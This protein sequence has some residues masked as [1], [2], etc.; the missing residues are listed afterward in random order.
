[1]RLTDDVLVELLCIR[2]DPSLIAFLATSLK[3][4][5][6]VEDLD[7][8]VRAHRIL[9]FVKREL[10]RFGL[11]ELFPDHVRRGWEEAEQTMVR[12]NLA[13]LGEMESLVAAFTR[14]GI[15]VVLLEGVSL[16]LN[17]YRSVTVRPL[18]DLELLVREED[19]AQ[20]REIAGLLGYESCPPD[21]RHSH[22]APGRLLFCRKWRDLELCLELHYRLQWPLSMMDT[23]GAR[24][25]SVAKPFKETSLP[26]LKTED[27]VLSLALQWVIHRREREALLWLIDFREI[28]ERDIIFF[29]PLVASAKAWGLDLCLHLF[30]QEACRILHTPPVS[31]LA[32]DLAPRGLDAVILKKLN[33][34]RAA[35]CLLV[36]KPW[37]QFFAPPR[38]VAALAGKDS[39]A[40]LAYVREL[41][42]L[43]WLV[44]SECSRRFFL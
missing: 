33:V 11:L 44:L 37:R 1:M 42:A 18:Y 40:P 19:L 17:T 35:P 36:M 10:N 31:K 39:L 15:E 26:H 43:Q 8:R 23:A 41:A 3:E 21:E 5:G 6:F 7:E 27:L 13:L 4:K 9:P 24:R 2:D 16:L 12:R 14:R 30:L 38:V 25:R 34:N 22:S 28:L 29:E 20:A 32:P